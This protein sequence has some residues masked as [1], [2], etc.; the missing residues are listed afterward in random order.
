MTF[1]KCRTQPCVLPGGYSPN[2]LGERLFYASERPVRADLANTGNVDHPGNGRIG[3]P[4]GFKASQEHG[5][6]ARVTEQGGLRR[7]DT[8]YRGDA[9]LKIS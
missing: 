3:L 5:E 9:R 2:P 7:R 4:K 1:G 6:V 8:P